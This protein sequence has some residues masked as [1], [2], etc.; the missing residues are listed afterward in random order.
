[1]E[2]KPEGKALKSYKTGKEPCDYRL[3]LPMS[4]GMKAT[5]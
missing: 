3:L 2:E 5:R 1:M 4:D